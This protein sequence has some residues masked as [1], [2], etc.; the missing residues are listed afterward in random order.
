ARD[1]LQRAIAISPGHA[2]AQANLGNVMR[3]LGRLDAALGALARAAELAPRDAEIAHSYGVTLAESGRHEQAVGEFRRALQID[4]A[5]VPS[6]VQLFKE[7]NQRCD[8][9]RRGPLVEGLVR[10]VREGRPEA[11]LIDPQLALYLPLDQRATASVA[12]ARAAQL[13]RQTGRPPAPEGGWQRAS[14]GDGRITVG[15]L[16]PDFRDH[17]VAHLSARIFSLHDRRRF[18]VLAYSL[19]PDDGSAWRNEVENAADE[20][21]ELRGVATAEAADLIAADGVDILVDLA[22]HTLDARPEILALRPAALQVGWLGYCGSMGGLN[23]YVMADELALPLS[24]AQGFGEAVVHLPETFMPIDDRWLDVAAPP[25]R[26][27]LGLP[28]KALVLAAFS[29]PAKIEPGI[30]GAWMRLLERLPAAVLW[31]RERG[32]GAAQNLGKAAAAS[33]IDPARLVFA[34]RLDDKAAHLSR[35]R[36]ADLFLDTAVYGAHTTATDALMAGLPV[37]TMAGPFRAGWGPACA[38]PPG[39]RIWSRGILWGMSSRRSGCCSI[40]TN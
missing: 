9:T 35:H 25:A 21:V 34:P 17:P 28:E 8:W 3:R 26:S 20:F 24:L 33:G 32:A 23:D 22:G 1:M 37:L 16:S 27:T 36:A 7:M 30:F 13:R 4:R 38:P 39:W 2:R 19:G 29:A 5:F 10:L 14:A 12:I 11:A 15:Y 6:A 40:P 18:R 31:L